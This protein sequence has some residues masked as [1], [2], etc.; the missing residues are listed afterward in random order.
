MQLHIRYLRSLEDSKRVRTACLMY[1]QNCLVYFYPERPDIVEQAEQMATD[2]GGQLVPPHMLWKYSWITRV[3]GW[4]LAKRLEL[5]LP[6]IRWW[7]EKSWDN[8]LFHI[9]NRRLTKNSGHLWVHGD[10]SWRPPPSVDVAEG[11]T[12]DSEP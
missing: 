2:L 11:H 1:L 3:F 9:E 12:G 4:S 10:T 7:V 8:A 5:L 6:R